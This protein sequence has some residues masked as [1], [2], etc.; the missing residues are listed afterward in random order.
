M[1]IVTG[2]NRQNVGVALLTL[3][4][5]IGRLEHGARVGQFAPSPRGPLSASPVPSGS[6]KARA[7]DHSRLCG[8][9]TRED[10]VSGQVSLAGRFGL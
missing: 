2:E 8:T 5:T 6:L 4:R 7:V 9:S 1:A 3:C 10:S